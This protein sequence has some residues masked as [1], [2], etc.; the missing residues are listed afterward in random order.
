MG[1]H[2]VFLAKE[3]QLAIDILFQLGSRVT[4]IFLSGAFLFIANL[5]YQ[6]KRLRLLL[7]LSE[8]YESP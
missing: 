2:F 1:L 6:A 4:E 8:F 7:I 3:S 5:A